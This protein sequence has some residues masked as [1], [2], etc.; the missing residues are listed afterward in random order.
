MPDVMPHRQSNFKLSALALAGLVLAAISSGCA[1]GPTYDKPP[2]VDTPIA[3]KEG[4]GQWI[5]AVPADT[6]ERGPWWQLFNDPQFN[7]LADRVEVSNQNVATAASAYAQARALVAVQ[8]ASL[9]PVVSLNSGANRSGSGGATPE[10]TSFQVGLGASWE[11]DLFGR[12]ARGT[13]SAEAAA[14][15]SQADL[16]AARLAM[17]GELAVNY[18]NLRQADTAMA[19]QQIGRAHV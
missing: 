1:V 6:L 3:F 16:A 12:L 14:Q 15:A 19:L 5:R 17:Q 13:T 11:P 18:F 10:R 8:R 4:Q 9:L 7:A 2:T